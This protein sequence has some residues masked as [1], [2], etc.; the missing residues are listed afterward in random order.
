MP[1]AIYLRKSRADEEAEQRGEG[2]TLARHEKILLDLAV[3]HSLPVTAIFKE[4]VSGETISARPEMQALLSQVEQGVFDGVL[5]VEVERLARGDTI[6]QGLV[7]QAFKYSNT[8]IITP[9]KVYNPNNEFD[10]E[11]F[12]FGLFMSR[13]EYKTTRRR[14][15]GGRIAS[16]NEGKWVANRAPYGYERVKI[17]GEKG[18]TLQIV[19]EQ[20]EVVRLIFSF[21]LNGREENG[22]YEQIGCTKIAAYLNNNRIPPPAKLWTAQTIANMLRNPSY[23]GKIKWGA[24]AQEKR[25]INGDII[26][27]RP[28][29]KLGEYKLVDGL[30]EA[31]ISE[32][33]FNQA[34]DKLRSNTMHRTPVN[35]MMVNPF[36]GLIVCRGCGKKLTRRSYTDNQKPYLIC[37]NTKCSCAAS[38]CSLIESAIL[39]ALA[40]ELNSLKIT[41]TYAPPKKEASLLTS[42][43]KK[44]ELELCRLTTQMNTLYDLLEQ[45]I[46][47]RS[48]FQSRSKALSE[49]LQATRLD[50]KKI[51]TSLD[52]QRKHSMEQGSAFPHTD[53]ILEC[54]DSLESV[55]AKNAL[56][57]T[58]LKSILYSKKAGGRWK[59]AEDDFIL[60][61]VL[62]V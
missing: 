15:E 41:N 57:K 31:I 18:Y 12:E 28:R 22:A 61:L 46:Y 42:T 37:S 34:Q 35:Q 54:Y 58:L 39:N 52:E 16:I 6:D 11:Y 26:V 40:L 47:D 62:S 51:K 3:K 48:T 24:R 27:S 50:I 49:R 4:I 19:P 36:A 45:G 10:E 60:E 44:Q 43:L 20:A 59:V 56:L 17:Q 55:E 29:K 23:M 5:V 8:K 21:Y 7:A 30:H 2:E 38:S 33:Q 53:G 32:N 13:R 14:M 1:Y 25:V 9:N